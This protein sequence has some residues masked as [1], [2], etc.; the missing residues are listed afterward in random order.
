MNLRIK[1][2]VAGVAVSLLLLSVL[3]VLIFTFNDLNHG[4]TG[5]VD[6]ANKGMEKSARTNKSIEAT[7]TNL[8]TLSE[9]MSKVSSA[10]TSSNMSIRI[11]A[12]KITSLSEDLTAVMETAEE[13]YTDLPEGE[14]KESVSY[15]ADD[16][17]DIQER[18]KREALVGLEKSKSDMEQFVSRIEGTVTAMQ[19]TG[20]ALL[21]DQKLSL[22][23][24]NLNEGI[25]S[26]AH[27][28]R[29]KIQRTQK[30]MTLFIIGL[31]I[32][33]FTVFLVWARTITRP[34]LRA[35]VLAKTVADKNF[36]ETVTINRK[37]EIGTLARALN[38]IVKSLATM[39]VQIRG[40]ASSVDASTDTLL[41][42]SGNLNQATSNMASQ[43]SR[44][45]TAAEQTN[46]NMSSIA[47]AS[48]ETSTNIGM[49]AAAAEEM[50]VT[51]NE[52]SSQSD[53]ARKVTT[54]G[55]EEAIRASESVRLLGDSTGLI[56]KVTD[57]INEIAKQTNLLALNATIE[58]ARAGEA[59]KGFAV[60]ANEIKEL[61]KQTTD[62]TKEIQER[63]EGV[64]NST[65]ET[66]SV[67]NSIT[68]TIG[69][70][71][72]IVN[73]MAAA[74]DEQ[75]T[76]SQEIAT[77]ISQASIGVQEVNENIAKMTIDNDEI[78][79]DISSISND[80]D[81]ISNSS[82]ELQEVGDE[83][84]DDANLLTELIG[85]FTIRKELFNV[86]QVRNAHTDW[87]MKMNSAL[88]GKIR[89]DAED[90]PDCHQCAFGKW[91]DNT[92]Q[93]IKKIDA[94]SKVGV[95]HEAVHS[96]IKDVMALHNDGDSKRAQER[97]EEFEVKRKELFASLDELYLG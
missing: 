78:S 89:L 2:F 28:F 16:I 71:N 59:G 29:L 19:S 79:R 67:M 38:E 86:G 85:Q 1:F 18:M 84:R 69:T 42:L 47:A 3:A 93:S 82:A 41:E 51:I 76:T 6:K 12:R 90:V 36:T 57:T 17:M 15:L 92:P 81:M 20:D 65:R 27:G 75:A 5:I 7:K 13:I 32:I 37:D 21:K 68:T 54:S 50:T 53:Q 66:I 63:V 62:A 39:L 33:S 74:V 30:Q 94:Y 23:V 80:A 31:C 22:E 10:I 61:A 46:D 77:N 9:E 40:R 26:N 34:L 45:A 96:I 83:M 43:C 72:E 73:A 49:V 87:K 8:D 35:T 52:I 56:G 60:V 95:Q 58:A 64:Q 55:V 97:L 14:A 88:A 44:I 25:T 4:F 48:E 91:Y 70:T 24:S 11:T